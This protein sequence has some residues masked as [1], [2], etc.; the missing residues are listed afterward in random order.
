VLPWFPAA[1]SAGVVG[2]LA[3]LGA[4]WTNRR[5]RRVDLAEVMRVAE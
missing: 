4:A 5:A 2:A 1:L 3:W